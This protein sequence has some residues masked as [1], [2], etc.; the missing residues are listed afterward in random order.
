[1]LEIGLLLYVKRCEIE[2]ESASRAIEAASLLAVL[3]EVTTG[4]AS[5]NIL[6]FG[7]L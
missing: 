1:M 3:G 5:S 7:I 4:L 2:I 6:A